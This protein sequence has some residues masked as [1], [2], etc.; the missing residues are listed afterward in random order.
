MTLVGWMQIV[1]FALVILALT[2][3][4]GA[5]LYRV[6]EGDRQPLPRLFAPLERGLLRL[7]GV[8]PRREQTWVEYAFALLAFS[9]V[10]LLVTY[11]LERLQALLP[12]NPQHFP[13]VP[14]DL[15]FNTAVS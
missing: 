14:A 9:A 4:L 11:G 2:R 13:A 6:F 15:A 1:V 3:P 8:D 12:L 10:S 7:C 5:Y